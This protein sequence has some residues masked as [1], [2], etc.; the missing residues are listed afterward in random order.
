VTAL[1]GEPSTTGIS[2]L[3]GDRSEISANGSV[4]E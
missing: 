2:P 4:A 1:S 3:C